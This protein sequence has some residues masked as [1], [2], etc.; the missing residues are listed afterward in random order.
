MYTNRLRIL[1][2]VGKHWAKVR[3]GDHI[4]NVSGPVCV[5]TSNTEESVGYDCS[6]RA[7]VSGRTYWDTID[8]KYTEIKTPEG[9]VPLETYQPR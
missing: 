9:W 7:I 4:R 6:Q 3:I 5:V 8:I 2:A 1:V